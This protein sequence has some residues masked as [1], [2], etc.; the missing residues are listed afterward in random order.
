M[1]C[2]N[3]KIKGTLGSLYKVQLNIN[4]LKKTNVAEW[5]IQSDMIKIK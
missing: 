1:P 4:F 3:V 5:S 2:R